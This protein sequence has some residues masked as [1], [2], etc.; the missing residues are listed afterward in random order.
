MLMMADFLLPFFGVGF[1][2]IK[3]LLILNTLQDYYHKDSIIL[4][5]SIMDKF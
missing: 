4:I 5:K 2:S 1:I 3:I